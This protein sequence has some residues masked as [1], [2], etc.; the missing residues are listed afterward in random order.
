MAGTVQHTCTMQIFLLEYIQS[1]T[2]S[3]EHLDALPTRCVQPLIRRR[4]LFNLAASLAVSQP[5][6]EPIPAGVVFLLG[7]LACRKAL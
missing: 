2:C 1:R 5:A 3:K 4:Q 6:G 7:I